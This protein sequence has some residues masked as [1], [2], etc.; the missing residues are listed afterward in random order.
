MA[1]RRRAAAPRQ[2]LKAAPK[3]FSSVRQDGM[4]YSRLVL[5][6]ITRAAERTDKEK[7]EKEGTI[8]LM[9][10]G[11]QDERLPQHLLSS[12]GSDSLTIRSTNEARFFGL[13]TIC[14]SV[15]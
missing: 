10:A 15:T 13:H 5:R 6:C 8:L 3:G 4:K 11:F 7:G 12:Q 1:L 9:S 2:L 14:N